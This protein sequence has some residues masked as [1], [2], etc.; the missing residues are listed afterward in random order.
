MIESLFLKK[1]NIPFSQI[2]KRTGS[3]FWECSE[4]HK[5]C[6]KTYRGFLKTPT[7]YKCSRKQT[8]KSNEDYLN[9]AARLLSKDFELTGN[10]E[11]KETPQG[12]L[13]VVEVKH[14]IC[15]DIG[16]QRPIEAAMNKCNNPECRA[17]KIQTALLN[18]TG[19]EM[20]LIIQKR[21][22]TLQAKYGVSN[23][24]QLEEIK[25]K[26]FET[27]ANSG[28]KQS[29]NKSKVEIEL[30]DFLSANIGY[31]LSSARVLAGKDIDIYIPEKKIGIEYCGI[32]WHSSSPH[33][34]RGHPLDKRYHEDKMN[35]AISQDIHLI[36]IFEDEYYNH[37]ILIQKK[38]LQYCGINNSPRIHS[39]KC[40]IREIGV[41]ESKL[42]LNRNHIQGWSSA[43]LRFG[44][45][46]QDKLV[47]VMQFGKNFRNAKDNLSGYELNRFA[48]DIDYRIPGIF[49]KMLTHFHREHPE[50]S[51]VYSYADLRWVSPTSN[52]YLNNGWQVASSSAPD[53]SYYDTKTKTRYHKSR[54][55]KANIKKLY[56]EVYDAAKTEFEMVDQIQSILRIYDCGKIKYQL[57]FPT[58]ERDQEKTSS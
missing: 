2:N 23:I 39:R 25:V 56:P 52:V 42:F 34:R 57:N 13:T 26:K 6:S 14:L 7:C 37:P 54:F 44:A 11:R 49:T 45:F 8:R 35:Q 53:Y 20:D 30:C 40:K 31:K 46:E 1:N 10:I 58:N 21:Q 12:D 51:T 17:K 16:W 27:M 48:T 41:Q 19:E 28:T 3:Y 5:E 50:I 22:N 15:G 32:Y 9:Q 55:Q 38:L 24:S 18:K 43:S 29:I 36:Q 4:C 33:S 47:A